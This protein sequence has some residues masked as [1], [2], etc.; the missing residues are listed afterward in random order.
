MLEPRV[1]AKKPLIKKLPACLMFLAF[2]SFRSL[3]CSEEHATF[4]P[5]PYMSEMLRVCLA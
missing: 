5:Y 1:W 3:D 4:L 2:A